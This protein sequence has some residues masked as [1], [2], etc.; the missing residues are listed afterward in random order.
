MQFRLNQFNAQN[1]V[2][3]AVSIGSSGKETSSKKSQKLKFFILFLANLI[4][5]FVVYNIYIETKKAQ[6]SN[7][8]TKESSFSI[9]EISKKIPFIRKWTDEEFG[10]VTVIMHYDE[11]PSILYSGQVAR[12]GDVIDGV[13]ILQIHKDK[14]EFERKGKTWTQRVNEKP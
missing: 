14:V 9:V 6:D 7:S 11:K 4:V 1:E 5:Y 3:P 10:V 13:K 2:K 8:N 12:E